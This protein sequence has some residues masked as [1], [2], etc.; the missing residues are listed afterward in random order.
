MAVA[1]WFHTP[2]VG[3]ID[4]SNYTGKTDE[5]IRAKV[6]DDV[7]VTQVNILIATG[8]EVLVEQ[9]E[10]THEQGLWYSYIT[11]ANCPAGEAGVL[12][13]GFDL[14][15]HEGTSGSALTVE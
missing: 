7:E 3:D 5:V 9:G 1:D 11:T 15:G 14:P 10:M 2:E 6:T 8:D 12:V 13:T 4:L